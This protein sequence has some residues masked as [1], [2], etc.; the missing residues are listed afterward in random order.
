M[1]LTRTS[2]L[3]PIIGGLMLVVTF[4]VVM[5][6]CSN[7]ESGVASITTVPAAPSPDADSPADTIKTLTANV[8]ELI[9]EVEA[10]RRDNSAL[11][12]EARD[13]ATEISNQV[14]RQ[15]S[16]YNQEH[17]D[18][19]RSRS[20]DLESLQQRLDDLAS[21]FDANTALL[22]NAN[23]QTSMGF[24]QR[25]FG[26]PTYNWIRPIGEMSISPLG[27][28]DIQS[29]SAKAVL[30]VP[31]NAT[32]IDSTVMTA[33]VGRVPLDGQV[34]DPMP[35]KVLTGAENLAANGLKIDG[36]HGM[37][38]SGYGFGDWTLSCVSGRL[39]SV[40][41]VFEDGSIRTISVASANQ[42]QN[43]Q[44]LGWISDEYGVPCIAGE[45]KSNAGAYLSQQ[46]GV[47]A[48]GAAAQ[49]SAAVETTNSLSLLG[50][51]Q[52]IVDGDIGKY[53]LGKTIAGAADA[54]ASWLAER[55]NQ[56]YDAI[57]VAAGRK[58]AIHVDQELQIDLEQG[59]RKLTHE[60][61]HTE[62]HFSHID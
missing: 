1:M 31:R 62:F 52:S 37:V 59:G 43:Q 32:L 40:T 49:A 5:K 55:A 54:T 22:E 30:T 11:R 35:F 33:L 20:T 60:E 34:R 13:R 17:V 18:D 2:R 4:V 36:V 41:F 51:S 61:W 45:R 39:H 14:S 38:W 25:A 53:V 57:F 26:Q 47:G 6:S 28:L 56:E 19:Q 9:T 48:V 3:L 42:S 16:A 29:P 15:I 46:L 21:E 58:V 7:E 23:F 50:A 27:D 8:S 12:S 24:D 44:S 10:L